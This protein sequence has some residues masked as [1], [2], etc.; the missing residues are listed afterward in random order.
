MRARH[1]D[2]L[3]QAY[4]EHRQL[5]WDVCYRMTGVGADADELVQETFARAA[6]RPPR[7]GALKPWLLKIAVNLAR[8]HLRARKRRGYVGP[9]LPG[10]VELP[11]TE[12]LAS[13]AR[14][15]A[16]HRYD[17]RESASIGF[18]LALEAL[19]PSQRA[20]LLLTDVFDA[21]V[22]E[23]AKLLSMSE[24]AVKVAHHRARKALAAYEE[25]RTPLTDDWKARNQ[26]MLGRFLE[27]L[28]SGDLA[29]A[30]A[31][32]APDARAINDGGGE[33][34]QAMNTVVGASKVVRF[35][36]GVAR[37]QTGV[38]ERMEWRELNGEPALWFEYPDHGPP[39]LARKFVVRIVLDRSGRIAEFHT[40]LAPRKLASL[41][42]PP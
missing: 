16:S 37:K 19:G 32:L 7:T 3:E 40:L 17:L 30:Q 15:D 31:L 9:W 21:S 13:P 6:A 38:P 42:Q 22:K 5:L 23:V 29:A 14:D 18:L 2:A 36:V 34:L 24:G 20:V 4:G 10:V 27:A 12:H 11:E 8:D 41:S 1:A 33:F 39:K 28:S 35:V 26:E 25:A